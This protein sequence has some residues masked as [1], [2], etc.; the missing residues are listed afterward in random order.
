M[1]DCMMGGL[2]IV[3]VLMLVVVGAIYGASRYISPRKARVCGM[4]V[5][6]V[7]VLLFGWHAL[8]CVTGG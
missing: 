6:I 4:S 3:V 8:G 5:I 7:I 2:V 1:I